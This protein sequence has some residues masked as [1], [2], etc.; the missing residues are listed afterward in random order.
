MITKKIAALVAGMAASSIT[1]AAFAQTP[2]AAPVR[3]G[4]IVRFDP[5]AAFRGWK[6][7]GSACKEDFSAC[8]HTLQKGRKFY[9]VNTAPVNYRRGQPVTAER[10]TGITRHVAA[11]GETTD[12]ACYVDGDTPVLNFIPSNRRTIR[13]VVR[14]RAGNFVEVTR[15]LHQP[16]WCDFDAGE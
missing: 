11:P 1:G 8:G 12:W 2:T 3:I 9:V 13:A 14:D 16:N 10:V 4:E 15:P 6:Y 5:N 7:K